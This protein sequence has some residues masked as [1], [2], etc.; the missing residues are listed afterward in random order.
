MTL[1]P[2]L[3]IRY[4]LRVAFLGTILGALLLACGTFV[5]Y[6]MI[7][8]RRSLANNLTVLAD[9]LGNNSTAAL[10]FA[11]ETE[12]AKSDAEETLR[13]LAFKH[14]VVSGCL[15]NADG[16]LFASYIRQP[17]HEE[18]PRVL[19]PDGIRFDGNFLT[20]VRPIVLDGKRIGSIYLKST[21][22]ELNQHFKSYVVISGLVFLCVSLLAFGLSTALRHLILRPISDLADA[23]KQITDRKDYSVRVQERT[24]DEMG[25]L[26]HAFNEMLAGIQERESALHSANEA[27]HESEERLN[28]ALEKSHTGG[29]DLDL[30]SH[31]AYRSLEHDRIFGYAS[32]LPQWTYEMFLEHVIAEDRPEVD[33]LFQEA[34]AGHTEWSFECRIRRVDGAVRWIWGA[35]E[36]QLDESG[37]ASRMAGIV[38]DITAR[39]QAEEEILQL[40]ASLEERVRERTSQLAAANMELEA[41][42]YSVSHDLRAPLRAVDGFSRMVLE[43]YAGKLDEEGRRML[44][45]IRSETQRMGRLIDDLLA[46]SRLGRQQMELAPIDMHQMAQA[47]FDELAAQEPP[48]RKL[49]LDLQPLPAATGTPTMMRQV[50][51]NLIGNAIKFT[52]G[53]EVGEIEIAAQDGGDGVPV[54][55]VKDNGAGFDMRFADKLFGV[56]QRLHSAEE[57]P[58]TGVGLALVQRI[59]HR[60]GGRIWA[61]SEVDHGA[62]FHFIIPDPIT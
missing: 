24:K 26:A 61:E 10:R 2:D 18:T 50:W 33:R 31:T 34:I 52:K 62:T 1:F 12:S 6:D 15:Y 25:M 17:G 36:H 38:Q 4:K 21:Q 39:K 3:P 30:V 32:L 49:R 13:A 48:G 42:S 37:N 58:G 22:E 28:F 41:F 44:G 45:V 59:V 56:F 20:I 23:T 47:V 35:G 9:A 7:S 40:N 19:G 29:W 5:I 14:A 43:D 57:F 60:H 51:V 55:H 46:F 53:R 27:L 54:Y 16:E 8:F 11:G